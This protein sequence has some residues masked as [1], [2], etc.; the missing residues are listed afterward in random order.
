MTTLTSSPPPVVRFA[1]I[2]WLTAVAAGAFETVLAVGGMLADGTA[3]AG[4]LISGV[5]LRLAVFAVAIFLTL[6]LRAG[7]NWARMAIAV[8]LGVFGLL[9]MV[10]EPIKDLLA[11]TPLGPLDGLDL[12][13][14]GSRVVH[15]LAVLT[16]MALMFLPQANAYFRKTPRRHTTVGPQDA[17]LP[18]TSTDMGQGSGGHRRSGGTRTVL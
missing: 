3:T 10:I 1:A 15:V 7:R 17:A 11:G 4:A 16:A 14:A 13:F 5:G 8:M 9:S 2:A 12:L 18:D 6:R